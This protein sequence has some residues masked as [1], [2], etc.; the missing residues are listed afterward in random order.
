MAGRGA[1]TFKKRQK[2][3]QR[4]EKQQEKFEKRKRRKETSTG[5]EGLGPPIED[6]MEAPAGLPPELRPAEPELKGI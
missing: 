6:V 4:R 5:G 2:E 1:Q 3:Q